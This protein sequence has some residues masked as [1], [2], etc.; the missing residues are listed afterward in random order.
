[1]NK[2]KG[3]A[4]G[5]WAIYWHGSFDKHFFATM[6]FVRFFKSTPTWWSVRVWKVELEYF[7]PYYSK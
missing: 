5:K 1:M 6:P 2:E 3:F 4:F 7:V